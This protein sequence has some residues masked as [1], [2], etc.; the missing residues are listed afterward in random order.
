MGKKDEWCSS[1]GLK[2]R[3]KGMK[4]KEGRGKKVAYCM[5]FGAACIT[6]LVIGSIHA[7]HSFNAMK[8]SADIE[9]PLPGRDYPSYDSCSVPYY[10]PNK[11]DEEW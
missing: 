6:Y 3:A 11:M 4:E 9:N 2:Y 8:I 5:C 7:M 10:S 1:K